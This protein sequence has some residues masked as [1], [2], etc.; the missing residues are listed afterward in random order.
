[1]IIKFIITVG[2]G[3]LKNNPYKKNWLDKAD[4]SQWFYNGGEDAE[5]QNKYA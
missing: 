3:Y 4:I 1:M 2:Y 5:T